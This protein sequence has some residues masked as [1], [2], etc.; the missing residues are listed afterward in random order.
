MYTH[1][2]HPRANAAYWDDQEK[3]EM[4]GFPISMHG[5]LWFIKFLQVWG[6]APAALLATKAL[7]LFFSGKKYF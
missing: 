1:A 7:Q 4:H 6:F 3:Q 5:F 2:M